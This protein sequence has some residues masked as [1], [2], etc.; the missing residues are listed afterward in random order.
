MGKKACQG[1]RPHFQG[2]CCIPDTGLPHTLFLTK[3]H[4]MD[5][6]LT[7]CFTVFAKPKHFAMGYQKNFRRWD[8][9][10]LAYNDVYTSTYI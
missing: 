8:V 7:L 2:P 10:Y 3:S 1:R 5:R 6:V 9:L 4:P